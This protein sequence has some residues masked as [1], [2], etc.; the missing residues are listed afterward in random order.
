MG[1]PSLL[2]ACPLCGEDRGLEEVGGETVCR[3]CGAR[4]RR[5]QGA[6]IRVERPD[7]GSEVHTPAEWLDRLP[8]PE[9]ILQASGEGQPVRTAAAG[10]AEVT[11]EEVVRVAGEYLNRVEVWGE[12][13]PGSVEL[14]PDRLVVTLED[15]ASSVWP[16]DS[17]TA[18][19]T[20]SRTL[21]LKRRHHPLTSFRFLHDASFLWERL[22]HAALRDL[23]G[24]TGRGE[25]A[26][27]QPRITTR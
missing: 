13:R 4:Y 6:N 3:A 25:I 15:D 26:E 9:E 14:W 21:Q 19:Q 16:L 22:L 10:V 11:G 20:S 8:T 18:V 12:E 7:A 17:L 5:V 27:F 23:Y 2:W 1:I 24:R